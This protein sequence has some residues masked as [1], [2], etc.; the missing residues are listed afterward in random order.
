[1]AFWP[2]TTGPL[3]L[4]TPLSPPFIVHWPRPRTVY[5]TPL[6]GAQ[7]SGAAR[8][9]R[10]FCGRRVSP[11]GPAPWSRASTL[12]RYRHRRAPCAPRVAQKP[13][14]EAPAARR[15]PAALGFSS[16]RGRGG[17]CVSVGD[18]ARL[19]LR[20]PQVPSSACS[21]YQSDGLPGKGR[22]H[23]A[24]PFELDG[25]GNAE[26]RADPPRDTGC[27]KRRRDAQ[28]LAAEAGEWGWGTRRRGG[29]GKEERN[30]P[31][32][33]PSARGTPLLPQER[34]LLFL[35]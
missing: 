25:G 14:R 27:R 31:L 5:R 20:P 7:A 22:R 30:R 33:V 10:H 35:L 15:A 1:M 4:A 17:C 9:P 16:S 21:P 13:R 18:R 3:G 29:T 19:A 34:S 26:I 6:G 28:E 2:E 12:L 32:Q 8:D 11:R 23:S 24:R